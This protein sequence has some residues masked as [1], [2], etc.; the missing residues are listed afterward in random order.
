MADAFIGSSRP[1][2]SQGLQDAVDL[3]GV[4]AAQFWA[5]IKVETS[6]C[7]FLP[8][9]RPKI[10]FERHVFSARTAHKFDATHPAISNPQPGGYGAAGAAQYARLAAALALDRRAALQ[11]ASW[12]LGQVMGFNAEDVGFGD[13]EQMV[14]AMCASEAAQVLA[15]A[16]FVKARTLDGALR[17]RDWARFAAGYNGPNYR[18][19]NYDTRLAAAF[20]AMDRGALPDLDVRAGQ[21]YLSYLG[22]DPQGI[23]G[24]MGRFTRSAMHDFQQQHGLAQSDFFD[25]VTLGALRAAVN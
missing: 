25:A 7:G 2:D 19:N 4:H 8:D 24:V 16:T 5:V 10:L 17:S 13:V 6:G 20:E 18:L 9:R 11:S 12:G 1:L 3:L 15:M 14:D 22:F 21:L 23:D